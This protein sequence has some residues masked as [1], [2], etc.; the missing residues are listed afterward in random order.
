MRQRQRSIVI[1]MTQT[2]PPTR[3][4]CAYN[5]GAAEEE[6]EEEAEHYEAAE[7]SKAHGCERGQREQRERGCCC[8]YH[9][10]RGRRC[11]CSR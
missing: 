4:A 1:S 7:R 8:L 9:R 3:I 11:L 10:W 6:E 5:Q 2:C